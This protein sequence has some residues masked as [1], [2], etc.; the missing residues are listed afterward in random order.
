MKRVV[1]VLQHNRIQVGIGN[2][3]VRAGVDMLYQMDLTRAGT[4]EGWEDAVRCLWETYSLPKKH[5]LLV[6]PYSA[7]NVRSF[8]LPPMRNTRLARAV[9]DE[10]QYNVKQELVTD[11]IPLEREESGVRRVLACSCPREDLQRFI[12]MSERLGLELEGITIPVAAALKLLHNTQGMRGQSCIWLC[13]DG[14]ALLF[15]LVERGVCR[16]TTRTPLTSGPG[17]LNFA[18]EVTRNVSNTLQFRAAQRMNTPLSRIYYAGCTLSEFEACVS[19][20]QSLGLQAACLPRC[21]R[22]IRFPTAQRMSDWLVCSGAMLRRRLEGKASKHKGLNL[23]LRYRR[24]SREKP[25]R[26][27]FRSRWFPVVVTVLLCTLIWQTL[28]FRNRGLKRELSAYQIWLDNPQNTAVYEEALAKNVVYNQLIHQTISAQ[29]LTARLAVYPKMDSN[30]LARIAAVGSEK[31]QATV[32][33]YDS[34]TGELLVQAESRT[35]IDTSGYVRD[36]ERLDLFETVSYTGY[37]LENGLYTLQLKC[38][39]RAVDSR[40]EGLDAAG[41]IGQ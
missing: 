21:E 32:T 4:I 18:S 16:Y 20:I 23:Y 37:A 12:D 28:A 39:L 11:Y 15:L 7:F 36:L 35:T 2:P 9:Q 22:V 13:F 3:G 38:M 5:I 6:L 30:L 29:T 19:G 1:L 26:S 31:I 34:S 25:E 14:T 8:R 40:K 41:V 27:P 33:G 10:L 17:A 24:Y